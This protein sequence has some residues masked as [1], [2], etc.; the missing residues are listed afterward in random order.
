MSPRSVQR[1]KFSGQHMHLLVQQVERPQ[2]RVAAIAVLGDRAIQ[3]RDRRR[4]FVIEYRAET[5]GISDIGAETAHFRSNWT[6]VPFTKMS[7]S[8]S[9]LVCE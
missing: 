8:R 5:A 4:V 2:R 7:G 3:R 6:N 1:E 9:V